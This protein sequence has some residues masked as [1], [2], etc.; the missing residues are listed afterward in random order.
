VSST[1]RTAVH[2]REPLGAQHR[3]ELLHLA[4]AWYAMHGEV[5]SALATAVQLG[6][7]DVLVSLLE[8]YG[9]DLIVTGRAGDV[10]T[11]IEAVPAAVRT[12]AV[13][14]V[15]GEARHSR[16]DVAGALACVAVVGGG[17]GPLTAATG[18]RIGK[19][20]QLAGDIAGAEAVYRRV[21]CDGAA[22]VDEA[23][24]LGQLATVHWLRGDIDA[25]RTVV[26]DALARAEDCG[27]P[28]ALAGV[29]TTAASVAEHDGDAEA[30]GS[31]AARATS[32][33]ELGGDL[34]QL[35]RIHINRAQREIQLGNFGTGLGHIDEALRLSEMAGTGWF[36]AMARTNRGWA[37]RGLGRLDEAVA[38]FGAARQFWRGVGS[39]LQAYAQVGLGAIYLL[40]GDLEAAE[41]ELTAAMSIGER[42]GDHQ[43]LTGSSTLARARYATDPA[44]AWRLTEWSIVNAPGHWRNWAYLTAGWLALCD[45]DNAAARGHAAATLTSIR[46]FPDPNAFA[47]LTE[48]QALAGDD[49][50]R[51]A[52]MLADAQRQWARIGNPV[53]VWRAGVAAAHRSG[54][55]IEVAEAR[56]RALGVQPTAALAAGPLRAVEAFRDTVY[57]Q[58]RA[59]FMAAARDALSR[60]GR[61]EDG[62]RARETLTTALAMLPAAPPPEAGEVREQYA[63]VLT[64]LARACE[65]TGDVD[66]ALAWHLRLLENDPNDEAAHLGAVTTL[67]RAGRHEEARRRYRMYTERMRQDGHEPAPYPQAS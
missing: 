21:D 59:R 29:Y 4:I 27:D 58:D 63:T 56:L 16:G 6:D 61:D 33:A 66:A 42:S 55:Q 5:E 2:S 13:L 28:R 17:D 11:A 45:G 41:A 52:E 14:L 30:A 35:S 31:Y 34:I 60:F 18:R 50:A 20:R 53:F 38:E 3:R 44:A 49:H 22:P 25:A 54:T 26:A 23:I 7:P 64:A 32:A 51:A 62:A 43:A 15:E 19:I 10:V 8:R 57:A 48:L 47:E 46:R 1:A 36:T 67:A 37:Y 40:R 65:L 39:D 9:A 12:P 24:L